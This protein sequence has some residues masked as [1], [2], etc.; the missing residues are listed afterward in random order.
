MVD[1]LSNMFKAKVT[2]PSVERPHILRD[3][4]KSITLRKHQ[5]VEIG[6]VI[7][8]IHEGADRYSDAISYY[9]RGTNPMVSVE[10]QNRG[11]SG[12]QAHLPYKIMR[13]GAFRFPML[14]QKDILPLSRQKRPWNKRMINKGSGADV[15]YTTTEA[16]IDKALLKASVYPTAIYEQKT[17][18]YEDD[19]ANNKVLDR[20]VIEA[21]SKVAFPLHRAENRIDSGY[22]QVQNPL[23]SFCFANRRSLKDT[24]VN[25]KI[26]LKDLTPISRYSF[27]YDIPYDGEQRYDYKVE[28]K[29]IL[30]PEMT[31]LC[32]LPHGS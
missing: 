20:D 3:P 17:Q 10:Y 13:D 12:A 22:I 18:K 2:L 15:R 27:E 25:R 28:T 26:T 30:H 11:G 5:P 21:S 9:A 1:A 24:T 31:N 7:P 6:D 16:K 32:H 14:R 4:Y 19:Y 23:H 29:N 8:A